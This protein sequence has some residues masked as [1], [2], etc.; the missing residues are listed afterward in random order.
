MLPLLLVFALALQPPVPVEL[1]DADWA[2][3]PA[4]TVLT[5]PQPMPG[6]DAAV[7]L[8]KGTQY[9]FSAKKKCSVRSWPAGVVSSE[10]RKGPRDIDGVFVGGTGVD[11]S[12]TFEGPFVYVLKP[13]KAGC[14]TVEFIPYGFATDKEIRSFKFD[15]MGGCGA[16]PVVPPVVDPL[17]PLTEFQTKVKAAVAADGAGKASVALYA[18]LYR[19]AARTTV[20]D[21]GLTT[22]AD[23]LKE[24]GRAVKQLGLP[25]GSL[26][27]TARAVADELNKTLAAATALD[28]ATREKIQTS[29]LIVATALEVVSN[30]Q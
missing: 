29:F 15:V 17:Q 14:V 8:P 25:A 11:E 13:L 3:F 16:A 21:P 18:A 30:G 22:A 5:P 20:L 12:R 24:M 10:V 2:S 4:V 9:T 26:D 23:L 6:P 19:Q 27:K 1:P 28:A 7:P